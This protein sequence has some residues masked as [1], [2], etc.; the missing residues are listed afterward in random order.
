MYYKGEFELSIDVPSNLLIDGLQ[1]S[2]KSILSYLEDSFKSKYFNE[3]G[4]VIKLLNIL[5]IKE[6]YQSSSNLGYTFL[7]MQILY[8]GYNI[9]LN[10]DLVG[11]IFKI[12]SINAKPTLLVLTGPIY[13]MISTILF[14]DTSYKYDVKNNLFV[15]STT[16]TTKKTLEEGNLVRFRIIEKSD[17]I[18]KKTGEIFP[19]LNGSLKGVTLGKI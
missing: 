12:D 9:C 16:K 4:Y 1:K 3:E 17:K 13:V 19:F 5:E 2:K 7:R 10:T 8:L 14:P 15:S 6:T 11:K 18:H